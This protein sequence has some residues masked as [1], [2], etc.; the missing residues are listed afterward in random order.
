[1]LMDGSVMQDASSVASCCMAGAWCFMVL[2]GRRMDCI[3]VG[4]LCIAY[5]LADSILAAVYLVRCILVAA[6]CLSSSHSVWHTLA[7]LRVGNIDDTDIFMT[8]IQG[9]SV[10]GGVTTWAG[11]MTDTQTGSAWGAVMQS[12]RQGRFESNP[13]VGR[14]GCQSSRSRL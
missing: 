14:A 7:V 4:G 3:V 13:Q 8:Q 11:V 10:W 6:V 1:M 12:C 2:H 5:L 9:G